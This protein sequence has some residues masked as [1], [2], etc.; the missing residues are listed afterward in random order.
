MKTQTSYHVSPTLIV[1]ENRNN[2][3]RICKRVICRWCTLSSQ[4]RIKLTYEFLFSSFIDQCNSVNLILSP[5]RTIITDFE[6]AAMNVVSNIF[7]CSS[8]WVSFP[9]R[10]VLVA[11]NSED[12]KDNSAIYKW[13]FGLSL[14]PSDEVGTAFANEIMSTIPA[15][16]RCRKIADYINSGCCASGDTSCGF[17]NFRFAL[18]LKIYLRFRGS[19][20]RFHKTAAR[21]AGAPRGGMKS[22]SI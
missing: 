10:P 5:A 13:L 20:L 8:S 22:W 15:D 11:Q 6:K 21:S 16:D 18:L 7:P 19:F 3:F 1:I 14:L 17:I 12:Y 9:P 4:T 2:G